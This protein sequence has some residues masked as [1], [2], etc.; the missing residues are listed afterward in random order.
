MKPLR[1]SLALALGVVL[2]SACSESGGTDGAGGSPSGTSDGVSVVGDDPRILVHELPV[3]P[4]MILKGKLDYAE[5]G[6]CLIVHGKRAEEEYTA[7]AIWPKGVQPLADGDRRGVE[8]PG[9]GRLLAGDSIVAAG[10]FWKSDDKRVAAA[11]IDS[12][13]RPMG[14]FIVFNADSFK[15]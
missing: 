7:A 9:F 4:G 12:A 13:C 5:Q 15:R 3:A 10:S 11:G 1:N 2:L 8:V 14:G 6:Q